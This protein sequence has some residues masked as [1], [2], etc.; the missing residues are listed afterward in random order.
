MA[1]AAV[2]GVVVVAGEDDSVGVVGGAVSEGALVSVDG[3]GA[4][5][6]TGRTGDEV[7]GAVVVGAPLVS[8]ALLLAGSVVAATG[9]PEIAVLQA[10]SMAVTASS[11]AAAVRCPVRLDMADTA[12]PPPAGPRDPARRRD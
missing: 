6:V 12:N 10:A 4:V 1:G 8:G 2:V 11:A 9:S 5:G 7:S 3:V